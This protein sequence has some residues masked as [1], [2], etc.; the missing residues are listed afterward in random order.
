MLVLSLMM[1]LTAAETRAEPLEITPF[2][3]VNNNP[4][5]QIY[6]LPAETSAVLAGSGRWQFNL[7]QDIAS[8]YST[9]DSSSE[10]ILLDGE[11]YRWNL[12]ARYG[13]GDDFEVGLEIPF[14]LQDGGFL[15][16]FINDW[17]DTFGL[18]PGGRDSAPKT[19]CATST[20]K[21]AGSC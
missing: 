9:S 16:G 10:Q 8:I 18:S 1:L 7:T 14:I 15:D 4:L 21:T 12:S 2:R 13:L 11:L 6:G 5:S 19:A 3:T 17:H 20:Q